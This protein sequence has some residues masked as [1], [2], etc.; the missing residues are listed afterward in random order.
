MISIARFTLSELNAMHRAGFRQT[1]VLPAAGT[2]PYSN[3]DFFL[4]RRAVRPVALA[5]RVRRP[6]MFARFFAT[7]FATTAFAARRTTGLA[8]ATF[9]LNAFCTDPA[10]AA[11]VPSVAPIDSATLVRIASSFAGL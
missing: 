7:A 1:R 5:L 8:S 10:L 6:R 11:I 9:L 4:L 3:Y 2:R